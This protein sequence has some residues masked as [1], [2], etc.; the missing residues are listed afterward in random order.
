MS[1][2]TS[3]KARS[4]SSTASRSTLRSSAPWPRPAGAP[5]P[6][7]SSCFYVDDHI[8][9]LHAL[10]APDA[11]L[12]RTP[13][14]RETAA[15]GI[16][17]AALVA[18]LGDADPELFSDVDPSRAARAEPSRVKEI[19][20]DLTSRLATAW[21]VIACPTEGWARSL[22]GEPDTDRLWSEV[23][24]VTRLDEPDPVEAWRR[25]IAMLH[26][27]GALL[28]E[29]RFT[30]LRFRGPDTDLRVGLLDFARWLSATSRTSWGQEH[31]A[32]PSDGGG[33]HDAG[34][35]AH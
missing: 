11:L 25:H 34:P 18:I 15:L 27:R 8:R 23:A 14:W 16:E 5:A 29:R 1:A 19:A 21:T 6:E 2:S 35:E 10:H 7:T 20:R 4:S 26:E 13:P 28:D 24:A 22:F 33:L 3:R 17:G 9:R 30:A 31:V 12:D 32:Q